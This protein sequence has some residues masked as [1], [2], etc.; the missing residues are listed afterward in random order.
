MK[1]VLMPNDLQIE[2]IPERS[3]IAAWVDVSYEG[4]KIPTYKCSNCS[5][6][7][8][9]APTP[10]C[11]HCGS[12]MVNYNSVHE[13]YEKMMQEQVALYNSQKEVTE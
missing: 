10:Y 4:A 8:S 6:H 7:A 3:D 1:F 12:M 5:E 2:N 9:L 11:P 13:V